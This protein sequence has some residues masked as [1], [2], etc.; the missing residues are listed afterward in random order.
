MRRKDFR[1]HRLC[2][3]SPVVLGE[4]RRPEVLSVF[5]TY[6]QTAAKATVDFDRASFLM[7]RDL[8]AQ[9]I[10]AMKQECA[11]AA[12]WDADREAQWVWEHYCARHR[13][14]YGEPFVADADPGWDQEPK[15]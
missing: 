14:R 8:L 3:R 10:A 9:S 1:T 13:E 12:Q 15:P 2:R 4:S 5:H 7:D 11:G 6:I